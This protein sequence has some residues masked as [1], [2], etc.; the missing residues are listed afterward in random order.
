MQ[1][2][3]DFEKKNYQQAVVDQYT[4]LD[5]F[6]YHFRMALFTL[7]ILLVMAQELFQNIFNPPPPKNIHGQ[8]ALVTGE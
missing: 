5:H 3:D 8:L 7:R 6:K 4:F 2:F 1:D